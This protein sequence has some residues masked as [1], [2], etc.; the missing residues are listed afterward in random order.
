MDRVTRVVRLVAGGLFL[1][2]GA[3]EELREARN[4]F[5]EGLFIIVLIGLVIGLAGVVGTTLEWASTP[6]AQDI[7][8]TVFDGLIDMPWYRELASQLGADFTD[9]F[10]AQWNRASRAIGQFSVRPLWSLAGII[11]TP[12]ALIL[13][14]LVY[15]LLA[16]LFARLLGGE[17]TM[18]QTLG[19]TGLAMTPHLLRVV[20]LLPFASV[21]AVVGTWVLIARYVAL[22]QAHGLAW[23]R[24]FWATVLPRVVIWL[25][26]LVLTGVGIAI[27]SAFVPRLANMLGGW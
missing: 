1:R 20:G 16:H 7:Q 17:A 15:G 12:L 3:Y 13:S 9:P 6:S 18:N 27:F 23:G 11:T 25:L 24:A 22:K 8:Q 10:E 26:G 2:T 19:T 4:P 21:G 5:V 14:W